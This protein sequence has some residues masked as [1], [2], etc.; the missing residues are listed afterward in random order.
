MSD[1][2]SADVL[3]KLG[4]KISS[5]PEVAQTSL[6]G[7]GICFMFAPL[8]HGTT[9]RV[10][11]IRRQLGVHTTFNL[12]GPLTNPAR[13]PR[14]IIGVW[15][16]TLVEPMARVLV[17]LGI[18]HAWVVHGADGLDEV[19][20]TD[21]TY[22]AEAKSGNVTTFEIGP[23]DFGLESEAIKHLSGGDPEENANIIRG[24][25]DGS[26]R[27]AARSLVVA[28][29]AVALFVGGIAESLT[30]AARIAEQ[31]IDSGGARQKLEELIRAT[32]D[33]GD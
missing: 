29:A 26:R 22:V 1:T 27:D 4:V 20:I 6:N 11:G 7:A 13:A 25:L 16:R 10:A 33:C 15:H 19:T 3:A 23:E 2:G 30:D 17:G 28:N 9:A 21:R 5:E 18:E 32:L 31:S 12:L 14:Q 24:V 8:Y